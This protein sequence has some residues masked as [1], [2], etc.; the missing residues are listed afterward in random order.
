MKTAGLKL[1]ITGATGF[2]GSRAVEHFAARGDAVRA[3]RR[4]VEGPPPVP[5]VT[6]CAFRMPDLMNESDFEGLDALIHT[7]VQMWTRARPEADAVNLEGARR[8]IDAARA[9][10]VHLVYLS[11]LSAH[12]GA[13]SHYGRN[14]LAVEALFD[15]DRDCILR[16]GLVMD[17]KGGLFGRIVDTLRSSRVVPLVDGGRQPIQTLALDDLL[18]ILER[19]VDRRIAGRYEVATPQVHRMRDLYEAI[20]SGT[21]RRPLLVPVP[22]GLVAFGAGLFERLR[23]PAPVTRESVLGLKCLRAFDTAPDLARLGVEL[24][25]MDACARRLLG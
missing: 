22:L 19:I 17:R 16:L 18:R 7:A 10:N 25:P 13:E 11:T 14:K 1:G 6:L 4:S 5:G 21:P 9:R 23:I 20:L 12:D 2:I 24:E 15:P 3:F 8:L